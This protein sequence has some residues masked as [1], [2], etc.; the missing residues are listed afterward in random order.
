[1]SYVDAEVTTDEEEAPSW[2]AAGAACWQLRPKLQGTAKTE[3]GGKILSMWEDV[4]RNQNLVGKFC[5]GGKM[6]G[7]HSLAH[8]GPRPLRPPPTPHSSKSSSTFATPISEI[9]QVLTS[10]RFV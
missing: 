7:I 1:M 6:L 4:L 5:S 3:P 10:V 9:R 8:F 2:H